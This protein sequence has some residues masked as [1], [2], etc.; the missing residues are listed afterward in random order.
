[1]GETK[2]INSKSFTATNTV[3]SAATITVLV[4][5]LSAACGENLTTLD[6]KTFTNVVSVTNYTSVVVIRHDGGMTGVKPANLPEAF[7]AKYG[8]IIKTNAPIIAAKSGQQLSPIDLF[9]SQNIDSTFETKR[10]ISETR[11]N[12][13]KFQKTIDI[14]DCTIQIKPQGF[15]LTVIAMQC[16]SDGHLKTNDSDMSV[17]MGFRFGEEVS[18]QQIFDKYLEW[19]NVAATN[20]AE[21]FEKVILQF[22]HPSQMVFGSY[23]SDEF[24][25]YTFRWEDNFIA[26]KRGL[27]SVSYP[28]M[29][30]EMHGLFFG[31]AEKSDVLTFEELLKSVPALKEELAQKIRNQKAQQ[32]LFK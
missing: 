3:R 15:E 8:I 29:N 18:A 4:F 14:H 20:K 2:Y 16:D 28:A 22:R 6:G 13:T 5:C 9:L 27:L 21:P 31:S 1:M 10:S 11:T 7:R 23:G 12:Q 30:F 19:E 24:R 26:G 32:T 17:S 25:T